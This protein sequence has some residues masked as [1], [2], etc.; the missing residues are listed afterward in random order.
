MNIYFINNLISIPI[1]AKIRPATPIAMEMKTDDWDALP[2]K[3]A[4]FK[5]RSSIWLKTEKL[6]AYK[7][8]QITS[9]NVNKK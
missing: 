3:L 2:S 4:L 1:A 5:R 7:L 6:C 9:E 8:T